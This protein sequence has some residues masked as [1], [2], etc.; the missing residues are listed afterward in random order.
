MHLEPVPSKPFQKQTFPALHS[1]CAS[2]APLTASTA[3]GALLALAAIGSRLPKRTA[4]SASNV[5]NR[6][7][8]GYL[9]VIS[10]TDIE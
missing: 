9:L 6:S 4:A 1:H 7:M 3:A 2:A 8:I 5:S 10:L